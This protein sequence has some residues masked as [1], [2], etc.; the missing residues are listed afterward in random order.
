VTVIRLKAWSG[1]GGAA[2]LIAA[3]AAEYVRM[4]T[5]H[6]KYSTEI[7]EK[8]SSY[9]PPDEGSRSFG[10]ML[11]KVKADFAW[12]VVMHSRTDQRC[13]KW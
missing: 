9:M 7:R 4:S 1:V 8:L 12:T 6:Q 10:H 11:T 5:E 13:P 2:P 3:R